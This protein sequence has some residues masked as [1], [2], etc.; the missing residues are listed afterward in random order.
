MGI[1]LLLVWGL[2]HRLLIYQLHVLSWSLRLLLLKAPDSILYALQ[3]LIGS[4][5]LLNQDIA[6]DRALML[7]VS[8]QWVQFRHLN[9]SLTHP[10]VA[11]LWYHIAVSVWVFEI[12]GRL[13]PFLDWPTPW[14]SPNFLLKTPVPRWH[15]LKG[16]LVLYLNCCV[17]TCRNT[18]EVVLPSCFKLWLCRHSRAKLLGLRL[19][20]V[21]RLEGSF[22][23][24]WR[25]RYRLRAFT[26]DLDILVVVLL[27][28]VEIRLVSRNVLPLGS[29]LTLD[30]WFFDY[31][32]DGRRFL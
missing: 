10:I 18:K 30:W 5:H 7:L 2:L 17:F 11:I 23:I 31:A 16:S 14:I 13:L 27:H 22:L 1:L 21:H 19:L 15:L 29:F 24:V 28:F 3:L 6:A 12:S 20:N 4:L 8:S 9:R 26:V 25:F 32:L